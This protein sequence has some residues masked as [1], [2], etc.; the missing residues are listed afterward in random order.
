MIDSD[1]S[2]DKMKFTVILVLLSIVAIDARRV[3]RQSET[4]G[5]NP[6]EAVLA[7]FESLRGQLTSVT[8]VLSSLNQQFTNMVQTS[9]R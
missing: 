3:A 1:F 5:A 9:I 8:S 6:L 4:G 7:Q 2:A